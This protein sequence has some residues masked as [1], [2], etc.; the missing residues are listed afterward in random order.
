MIT[1]NVAHCRLL[2][3]SCDQTIV[4]V[5]KTASALGTFPIERGDQAR[6]CGNSPVAVGAG[7]NLAPK[8]AKMTFCCARIWITTTFSIPLLLQI[9]RLSVD[10]V[11]DL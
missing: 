10:S 9:R 2:G 1:T 5:A 3:A 6:T 8:N 7:H 4:I 11:D